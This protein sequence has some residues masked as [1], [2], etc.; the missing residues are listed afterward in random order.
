MTKRKPLTFF[1]PEHVDRSV[2]GRPW[3]AIVFGATAATLLLTA[4][5]ELFW[6]GKGLE[7]GDFKN[8]EA[9]WAQERR[10]AV[11]DATVIIGSSRIFFDIDL[12]LWEEISGVRPV[13]L[14]LEGTSPRV[15][16]KD[17]AEDQRFRGLVIV[18]VTAPLFFTSDGGFRAGALDYYRE[19]TPS[20]RADHLLA[21]QLEKV[22]AFIDDQSRPK[23]QIE[24][25]PFPLREGMPPRFDPRKLEFLDSDRNTEVWRR[26]MEDERYREEAKQ[27]WVYG[28]QANAPAPNPDGS[29]AGPMP[30]QAVSAVI[31]EVKANID[32]IRA[33]GGEVA[34]MRLPY[35]GAYT[36]VE[37]QGFPRAQFWDRLVAETGSVG[38]SWHDHAALQG[39]ELPEWSHLAPREAERYTRAVAPIFYAELKARGVPTYGASLR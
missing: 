35:G 1:D 9:L 17:L 12:D 20:Q 5:W 21:M 7:A 4:G 14:A 15:F 30:P 13:Q 37:D 24:I 8:T 19:E 2:P 11:G 29:P 33:R 34:F 6:R 16:L 38:V 28:T 27:H 10:K 26:V 23:R 32:R 39:Y 36:A 22:F 31:A 25:W 3:R 18:G